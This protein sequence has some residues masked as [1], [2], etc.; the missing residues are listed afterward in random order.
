MK[1]KPKVAIIDISINNIL[2]ISRALEF[3][4]C[5]IFV[6]KEKFDVSKYDL[7]ILPGVGAYSEGM[8]RLKLKGLDKS[9]N[10]TINKNIPL[11][12]ICLGMQLLFKSSSEFGYTKGIGFFEDEFNAF[13]ENEEIQNILIGWNKVQFSNNNS[14]LNNYVKENDL[15]NKNFYFVHSFYT[16][17]ENKRYEY[18]TTTNDSL[19]FSSIVKKDNV[20]AFQ[21]HPEKSGKNGIKLLKFFINNI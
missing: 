9:I 4:G 19:K 3:I 1:K 8:K 17:I 6:F 20:T 11:L 5:E 21:F 18:G 7:I 10:E 14:P 15:E 2:S 13:S 12:G 16:D